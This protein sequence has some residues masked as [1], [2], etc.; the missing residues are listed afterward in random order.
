MFGYSKGR[1]ILVVY[2]GDT[3]S[4]T[5]YEGP[6]RT[7]EDIITHM[8][9]GRIS[10]KPAST[11]SEASTGPDKATDQGLPWKPPKISKNP[12]ASNA[13]WLNEDGS[14][15]LVKLAVPGLCSVGIQE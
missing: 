5:V 4:P 8:T 13:V 11:S 9:R 14:Q 12:T 1:S 7:T 6:Q 15:A 2:H 3:S 10:S